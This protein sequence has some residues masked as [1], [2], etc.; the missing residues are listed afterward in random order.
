MKAEAVKI[1]DGVYW[2]GVLDWDIRSYH[3]YTLHG[4][5]YNA[6]LVFGEDRIA[7]I[8]NAYPG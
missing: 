2:V 6:Y 7:L 1:T 5:T 4:T 3:G 8:D